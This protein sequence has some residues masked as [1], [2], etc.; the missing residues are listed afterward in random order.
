[1]RLESFTAAYDLHPWVLSNDRA[2][3]EKNATG[4][5]G[6]PAPYDH[7][8]ARVRATCVVTGHARFALCYAGNSTGSVALQ[9]RDLQPVRG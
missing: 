5:A 1:M 9:L 2:A 7:E 4:S 3:D 6:E 8:E